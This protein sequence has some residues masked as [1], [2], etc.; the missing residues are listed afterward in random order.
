MKGKN[1]AKH[2][3]VA[4]EIAVKEIKKVETKKTK[5]DVQPKSKKGN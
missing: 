5:K 1:K 4:T 3:K 2:A